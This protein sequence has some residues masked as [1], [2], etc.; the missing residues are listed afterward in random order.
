MQNLPAHLPVHLHISPAVLASLP[1]R[2][3]QGPATAHGRGQYS[4]R[5]DSM[6]VAVAAALEAMDA[7]H[8]E[9]FAAAVTDDAILD[10]GEGPTLHGREELREWCAE[11]CQEPRLKM[12][13]LGDR[14]EADIT[15][16]G[17]RVLPPTRDVAPHD[18]TLAFTVEDGL[19]AHLEVDGWRRPP[20]ATLSGTGAHVHR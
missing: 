6:P 4:V 12:R 15:L 8:P 19:I 3:A 14:T 20:T 5:R 9:D 11:E 13:L 10:D 1:R 2:K 18:A 17:A 7:W 16:V